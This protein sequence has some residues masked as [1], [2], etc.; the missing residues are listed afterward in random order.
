MIIYI[1]IVIIVIRLHYEDTMCRT[2]PYQASVVWGK[3]IV[4]CIILDYNFV[5]VSRLLAISFE[6]S[7]ICLGTGWVSAETRIFFSD[8]MNFSAELEI[9]SAIKKTPIFTVI[10]K[11]L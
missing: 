8:Y 3:G 11:S 5:L 6:K 7:R 2:A 9:L 10:K 4:R 1:G